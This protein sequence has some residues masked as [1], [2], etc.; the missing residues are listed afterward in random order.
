MI[1]V[2]NDPTQS[3]KSCYSRSVGHASLQNSEILW[4]ELANYNNNWSYNVKYL[5]DLP[6]VI[7][8]NSKVWIILVTRISW[9][10]Q[11]LWANAGRIIWHIHG[12]EPFSQ[13]N[14]G[15]WGTKIYARGHNRPHSVVWGLTV[16][17]CHCISCAYAHI[18]DIV[19]YPFL[20]VYCVLWLT[21]ELSGKVTVYI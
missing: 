19:R 4:L 21:W 13:L 5:I 17:I 14:V 8:D 6:G 15:I 7:I 18:M 3:R 11:S 9:S 10:L 20:F 12:R 2:I 16:L 1:T